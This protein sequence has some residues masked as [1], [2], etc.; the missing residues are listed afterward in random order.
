MNTP[1]GWVE[2]DE[3]IF[4]LMQITIMRLDLTWVF[5]FFFKL[6]YPSDW[7]FFTACHKEINNSVL[8]ELVTFFNPL[9]LPARVVLLWVILIAIEWDVTSFFS[10]IHLYEFKPIYSLPTRVANTS[11]T[12]LY[13]MLTNINQPCSPAIL[14]GDISS[15]F[16]VFP[17]TGIS[18]PPN[19]HGMYPSSW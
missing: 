6:P 9:K 1:L 19:L 12:L 14:I 15:H 11:A 16:P 17:S 8:D 3:L 4:I 7:G 18:C 13:N 2:V 5:S 10:L